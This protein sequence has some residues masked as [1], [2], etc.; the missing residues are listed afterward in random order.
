MS[1]ADN[2]MALEPLLIARLQ[3]TVIVDGRPVDVASR[4]AEELSN[5][6][7][8]GIEVAYDGY[9]I[10]SSDTQSATIQ[11][12]WSVVI[13][14]DNVRD[15]ARAGARA[16]AGPIIKQVLRS[17]IGWQPDAVD[18]ERH[19][20]RLVL[21]TPTYRA[22]YRDKRSYFPLTFSTSLNEGP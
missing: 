8:T 22:T 15:K 4:R 18:G 2:F 9:T 21:A 16:D 12:S 14:E 20:S 7:R 1:T 6:V 11:Q 3:A 13:V 5:E 19:F 10:L 17:L